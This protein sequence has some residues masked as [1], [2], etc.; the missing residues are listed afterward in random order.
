MSNF[1]IK[2]KKSKGSNKTNIKGSNTLDKKHR[3]K[4]NKFATLKKSIKN[5]EK[6]ILKIDQELEFLKTNIK[7]DDKDLE[8]RANLLN[9]KDSLKDQLNNIKNNND[10]LSYYDTAGDIIMEYYNLINNKEKDIKESKSILE[11]L[12]NKNKKPDDKKDNRAT[13][14]DK[15][16]KRI[17]GIRINKHDGTDRIKYCND[18][19]IEK[20]LDI[21][22]SSY[23]CPECGDMEIV[24]IDEDRQIKEYSPYKRLNHFREWLNQ[25]QAK[26]STEIP[27]EVYKNICIEINRN[28]ITDI[29]QLNRDKMQLILKKLGYNNL[30]EHIPYIINKLSN[31]PP[32]KINREIETRFLKMFMMIQEPWELYKPKGRKN[33]LSYSYILYKFCELLELDELLEF[34]P[35]LKSP[36]KLM[37]Q[38]YVW[39]KFCTHLKWEFYPTRR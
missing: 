25:F 17:D 12:N 37:E 33:F 22:E 29:S 19:A 39:K 23:T 1:R 38:D 5:I 10:E 32:P 36:Q 4:V 35:L 18:C 30:Y 16:C 26:E 13:L 3:Q 14:F 28:R 11:Y 15:F 6:E 21:G 20:V 8:H 34:F 27:D 31:L 24:I 7:Y 2:K 9:K